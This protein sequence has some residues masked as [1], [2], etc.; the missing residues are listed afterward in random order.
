MAYGR[1]TPTCKIAQNKVQTVPPFFF[2]T[3]VVSG[4]G[5]CINFVFFTPWISMFSASSIR[6]LDG[7]CANGGH[8]FSP[9]Q[10]S[11]MG[12]FTRSRLEE[13]GVFFFVNPSYLR[14]DFII[15]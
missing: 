12:P 14:M 4:K 1:E 10:R 9:F 5:T 7:F 2:G 3:T 6:D 11:L 8:V 15:H 13:P